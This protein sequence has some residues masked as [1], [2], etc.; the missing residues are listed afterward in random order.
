MRVWIIVDKTHLGERVLC[1]SPPDLGHVS[2]SQ[3]WLLACGCCGGESRINFEP[4]MVLRAILILVTELRLIRRNKTAPLGERL[5]F[6]GT[7][8]HPI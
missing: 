4:A 7:R 6:F 2:L 3:L 8:A 1:T 5:A